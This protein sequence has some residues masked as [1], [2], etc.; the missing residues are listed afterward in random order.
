M[1]NE[2]SQNSESL[3]YMLIDQLGMEIYTTP[4]NKG[5]VNGQIKR[6][7]STLSEI[8]RCL[9]RNTTHRNFEELL[10]RADYGYNY[11]TH[12]VTKKRQNL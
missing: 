9:K 1:N 7:H 8:M 12:S 6:F 11:S 2:K 10:D 3:R 5:T 4:A